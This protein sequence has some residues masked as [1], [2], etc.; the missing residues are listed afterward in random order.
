MS[1]NDFLPQ[2][3]HQKCI[4]CGDCV[5]QCPTHAL[6]STINADGNPKAILAY[7]AL[8][9][10]CDLCEDICPTAAIELP[11]LISF[12]QKI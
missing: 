8:C 3:D 9:I 5:A 12:S 4:G 6:A 11:L 10:Y 7:P 1:H 2:I